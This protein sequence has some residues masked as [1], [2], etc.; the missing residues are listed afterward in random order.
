MDKASTVLMVAAPEK[1]RDEELQIP[2]QI[3]EQKG[4]QVTLA[5]THAGRITGMLGAEAV[6]VDILSIAGLNY[7]AILVVGGAGAPA[8]LWDNKTLHEIIRRHHA[9]G[10]VVAAICLSGAALAKAGILGSVEAT[11]YKSEAS[12]KVFKE[13]GVIYREKSVVASGKVITANGPA[14]AREFGLAVASALGL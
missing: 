3:L 11:V 9:Q 5:S 4:A 8:A 7:D 13:C 10:K 12:M 6:A 1:F 2:R 14:A